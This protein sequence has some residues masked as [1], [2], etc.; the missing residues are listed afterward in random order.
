M[1]RWVSTHGAARLFATG[2]IKCVRAPTRPHADA[3]VG[4]TFL[5]ERDPDDFSTFCRAFVSMF[6]I[7]IGRCLSATQV[8]EPHQFVFSSLAL[9]VPCWNHVWLFGN[10]LTSALSAQSPE[11]QIPEPASNLIFNLI[12]CSLLY[13]SPLISLAP[14]VFD[15]RGSFPRA[16]ARLR[17][18]VCARRA[19]ARGSKTG[20]AAREPARRAQRGLVVRQLPARP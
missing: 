20:L 13:V 6:R 8:F 15:L 2:A 10:S 17:A 12:D 16:C 18:R 1:A 11:F 19:G 4:V 7:T 14:L 9:V 3:V 5:G